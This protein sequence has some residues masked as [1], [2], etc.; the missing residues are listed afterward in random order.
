MSVRERVSQVAGIMESGW[1]SP[2]ELPWDPNNTKFPTRK[3]LPDIPG[4][5]K[6]AAW[7]WGKDDN[8]C[9]P[10]LVTFSIVSS[11]LKLTVTVDWTIESAHSGSGQ[12]RCY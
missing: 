12:G 7:V 5:P 2:S 8:V 9:V 1:K 10:S 11:L 4:A 3:N 6:G